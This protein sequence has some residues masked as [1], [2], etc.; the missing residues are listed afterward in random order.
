MVRV[1]VGVG[2]G[3]DRGMG[4]GGIDG[5]MEMWFYLVSVFCFSCVSLTSARVVLN[6]GIYY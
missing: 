6:L 4:Y 2:A 5:W 1:G 3:E